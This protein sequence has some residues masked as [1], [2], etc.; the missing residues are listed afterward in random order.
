LVDDALKKLR[1]GTDSDRDGV[2]DITELKKAATE[3]TRATS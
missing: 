3:R 2:P 1:Y